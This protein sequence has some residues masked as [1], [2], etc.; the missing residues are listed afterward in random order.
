MHALGYVVKRLAQLLALG[1]GH[2][3]EA[4]GEGHLSRLAV[5]LVS[6]TAL[7]F[8]GQV[9]VHRDGVLYPFQ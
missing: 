8:A 1:L 3:M 6:T 5:A 9:L 4:L 2:G 7:V